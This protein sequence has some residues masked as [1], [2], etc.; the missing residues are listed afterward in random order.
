MRR[1]PVGKKIM[2]PVKPLRFGL[3]LVFAVATS[4]GEVKITKT[5]LRDSGDGIA[6]QVTFSYAFPERQEI[7]ITGIGTVRATGTVRNYVTTASL[8]EFR[9]VVTGELLAR[10]EI[11]DA[12]VAMGGSESD[13]P[14]EKDFPEAYR[15]GL[16]PGGAFASQVLDVIQRYFPAG[17]TATQSQNIHQYTSMYRSLQVAN[18]QV[19]AEVAVLVAQPFQEGDRTRFR[20]RHIARDRPRL[21]R[22]WR[23]GEDR[24]EET[25]KA[26]DEFVNRLVSDLQRASR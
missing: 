8:L 7:A 12:S 21:S 9:D 13:L 1:F 4:A 15:S 17:F 22:Q 6:R 25:K 16:I 18:Q 19:K 11:D 24:A 14:K 2:L 3:L 5:V 10:R 26:T 20:L 23:Y